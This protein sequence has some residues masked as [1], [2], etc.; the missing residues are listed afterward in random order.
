MSVG[1]TPA[2][3]LTVEELQGKSTQRLLAMYRSLRKDWQECS[4]YYDDGYPDEVDDTQK[5]L[6]TVTTQM[7][8][9]KAIL[10]TREHVERR[11]K[12]RRH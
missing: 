1:V 4:T 6:E 3:D 10:N 7:Q 12:K 11:S 8:H 2:Q 9:I 5:Y